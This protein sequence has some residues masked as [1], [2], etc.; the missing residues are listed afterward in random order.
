LS[1]WDFS[2]NSVRPEY[3]KAGSSKD[4][5]WKCKFNHTWMAPPKRRVNGHGCPYCSGVMVGQGNSLADKDLRLASEWHPVK[6][7]LTASEVAQ[8]S[9]KKVWSFVQSCLSIVR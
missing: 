1:E 7:K 2:A 9:E 5:H 4:V 6:N 3:V 8:F